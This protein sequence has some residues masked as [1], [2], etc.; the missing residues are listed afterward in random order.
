MIK[1]FFPLFTP[2]NISCAYLLESPRRGD[3]NKYPQHMFLGVLNTAFLN[4]SNYLP[5]LEVRNRSIQIVVVTNFFVISNVV[6]KGFACNTSSDITS[7]TTRSSSS[8]L[9]AKIIVVQ[10]T[11]FIATF[12]ITTKLVKTTIWLELILSSRW[13]GLLEVLKNIVFKTSRNI[14]Y[15]EAI[16]TNIHSIFFWERLRKSLVACHNAQYRGLL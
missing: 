16:L 1:S 10:S 11:L 5:H 15:A 3:S 4:I 9:V 7:N 2:R 12:D 8:R 14:C 13:T 6:I